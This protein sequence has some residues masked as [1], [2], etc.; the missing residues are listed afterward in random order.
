M[1]NIDTNIFLMIIVLI[2][3]L[4]K[5]NTKFSVIGLL[6]AQNLG[7]SNQKWKKMTNFAR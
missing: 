4:H 2:L 7:Q 3:F 6:I 5:V 1:H